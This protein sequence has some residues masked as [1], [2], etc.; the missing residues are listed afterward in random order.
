MVQ[1]I[2]VY[3]DIENS[4]VQEYMTRNPL[5]RSVITCFRCG[6]EGHYKSECLQWK[7]RLCWHHESGDCKD[8]GFCSF[9]HGQGELRSPWVPRCMRVIKKDNKIIKIG[10]MGIGHTYKQCPLQRAPADP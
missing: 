4:A 9:A 1:P 5:S 6:Q 8:G 2:H 10:C 3:V 7:T